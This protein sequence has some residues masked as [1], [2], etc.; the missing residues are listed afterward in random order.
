M[1][2][3][4]QLSLKTQALAF[5]ITLGTLPV[6]GC[7]IIAYQLANRSF[8]EKITNNQEATA[9]TLQDKMNL[10][11]HDRF[12]DIQIMANLNIF[13]DPELRATVTAQQK[14]AALNRMKEKYGIYDSI[15]VFDLKGNV[16]AQTEGKPLG[17]HLNRT[18]I[19]A[20]KAANGPVLSQPAVSTSSGIFAVYA[21]STINDPATGQPIGFIRARMPVEFLEEAIQNYRVEN[22]EYYLINALGE[23][24]VGPQG[25]YATQVQ[26]SGA[27]VTDS[28]NEYT[29]VQAE[30]IFSNFNQL[31]SANELATSLSTNQATNN[32]QMLAYAPPQ[33]VEGLPP[34]DWSAII[35]TD[36]KA[37]FAPQRQLL[38]AILLGTGLTALVTTTMA[39][40][41]ARRATKTIKGI[42]TAVASSANEIAATVDQQERTVAQQASSVNETTTTMDELGAASRQAA[43]QAEASSNGAQKAIEL[44]NQGGKAVEE[45]REAMLN[46]KEQVTV[47]A[48][49]IMNLS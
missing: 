48:E 18:Y 14:S 46:L 13:T 15:G 11:M 12:R 21:A 20:A 29:A 5:A 1:L 23:V 24:F 19:Q 28:Q 9:T 30:N 3:K 10:F 33:Q 6:F 2:K 31:R 7:G 16:I 42:T 32:Q 39:L 47:I 44:V 36:S 35:A 8:T 34:L 49:Q 27:E 25:V 4:Q 38:Q 45:T 43:E 26:S 22:T 40:L 37:V 41:L 17:N